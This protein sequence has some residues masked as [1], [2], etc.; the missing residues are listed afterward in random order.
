MEFKDESHLTFVGRFLTP[1]EII[2]WIQ[3]QNF[4]A[5]PATKV[6]DHH[7]YYPTQAEWK[8]LA[9]LQA[10]FRYYHNTRGWPEG[11]GPHF[12]VEDAGVWVA[13]HPRHDGIG[14][15]GHN[16]RAIHI[17]NIG[18]FNDIT[19]TGS[20]LIN[21]YILK[22]ALA[23]KPGIPIDR[24]HYFFHSD[25]STKT[26]PGS[27]NT[28]SML[29]DLAAKYKFEGANKLEE[30]T[31]VSRPVTREEF[32]NALFA[33]NLPAIFFGATLS[34]AAP[35]TRGQVQSLVVRAYEFKFGNPG[36]EVIQDGRQAD[37][38]MTH[39]LPYVVERLV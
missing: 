34:P 1:E 20:Q 23:Q 8:G 18:N 16:Y 36:P 38:L 6:F 31:I 5:L 12:F 33:K 13:T 29:I 32:A 7:T 10:I 26:C 37:Y 11:I 39:E 15:A 21:N 22:Y 28:K 3:A 17:E 25:Y 30:G 4:G 2:P 19:L 24:Q 9:T 14:V 27:A 35:I